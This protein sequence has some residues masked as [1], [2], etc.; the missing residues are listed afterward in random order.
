MSCLHSCLVES[1]TDLTRSLDGVVNELSVEETD[2]EKEVAEDGVEENILG[3]EEDLAVGVVPRVMGKGSA[4]SKRGMGE[5]P[6]I[7][8]PTPR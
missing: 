6:D 3:P 7:P 4:G 8:P 2:S 5:Y 1:L